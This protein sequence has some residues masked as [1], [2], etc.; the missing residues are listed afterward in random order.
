MHRGLLGLL[1]R[2]EV[3]GQQLVGAVL[4]KDVLRATDRVRKRQRRDHEHLVAAKVRQRGNLRFLD[5]HVGHWG[6]ERHLLVLELQK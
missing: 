6:S 5:L 2:L 1:T 4:R 3:D